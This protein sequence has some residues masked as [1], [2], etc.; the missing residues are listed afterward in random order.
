M[1]HYVQLFE[2]ILL[3]KLLHENAKDFYFPGNK[4]GILLIHGF[5]GSPSEM[6]YLGDY[7]KDR[8]FS[9]RGVLLK[10]HGTSPEDMKKTNHKDWIKSAEDGYLELSE[11]CD[12]I[13]VVGFSMGGAIALHLARK[14]DIK[15]VVSLATPIR[16]LNRQYYIGAIVKY[17]SFAIGR[18]PKIVKQKDPFIINYDRT[19]IKCIISLIQLINMVKL[20]LHKVE[21][22]ILIM[23]SYGD[24]TVHPSSANFI[25]KRVASTDKSIIFLHKSGHV[26]TCDCEKEQVFDEIHNFINKRCSDNIGSQSEIYVKT[27]EV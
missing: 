19:S 18:Q 21:K 9:V 20:D 26:I 16:I 17:L 12:E 6:R 25:Y 1:L 22:P 13:F 3:I 11:S 15:G 24:G 5:T 8:N 14:Y 10:G 4:T 23:Q 27:M 2:V 7:L